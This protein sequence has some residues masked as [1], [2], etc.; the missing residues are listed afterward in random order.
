MTEVE[1]SHHHLIAKLVIEG[2]WEK[3]RDRCKAVHHI[4]RQAAVV[5]QHHQQGAHVSVDLVYLDSGAFQ[6][7]K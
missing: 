7:L 4:Q 1:V 6:K 3:A 2:V 5:T